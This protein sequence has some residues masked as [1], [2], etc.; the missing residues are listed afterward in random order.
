MLDKLGGVD[1]A[2]LI[3]RANNPSLDIVAFPM[4]RLPKDKWN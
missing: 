2:D 1:P 4:F 3:K